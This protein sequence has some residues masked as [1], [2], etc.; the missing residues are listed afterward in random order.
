MPAREDQASSA[1]LPVSLA[2]FGER[3]QRFNPSNSIAVAFSGGPDSLALLILAAQWSRSL[4]GG[5]IIALT[6]DH[7]LRAGSAAEAERAAGLAASLGVPHRI[8]S[9]EG[10]KPVSGI[11]AAARDARYRL[12][13]QACRTFGASELL[14][15]HHLEDQAET[16]LLRLRR[17]SG[18]DGLAAMQDVRAL[19]MEEPAVRLLRPLLDLPRERL[20]AT[21]AQSGLEPILDPSNSNGQFD[22]VKIRQALG[23][24]AALGFDAAGLADT[25]ARMARARVALEAQTAALLEAHATLSSFGHV[26][27]DAEGLAAAPDETRLRALAAILKVVGGHAYGPR[28]DGLTAIDEALAD[29]TLGRG[30]TLSGVKFS[31]ARGRLLAVRELAAAQRASAFRLVAGEAATWDGRFDVRLEAGPASGVEVRVLG[32]EGLSV[33]AAAGLPLPLAPKTALVALPA[34]WVGRTLLGAPHL[35]TLD[36]ASE[37]RANLASLGLFARI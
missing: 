30:R 3:M 16:F 14:V 23:A 26:E 8:L 28:M 4:P 27:A 29:D 22:R 35:G 37:A 12:L 21:V 17:G 25:A 7:G 15:A 2:A 31:L 33:L 20:A 6:V 18:V 10:P 36:P 32:V 11:Q 19:D 1:R 34:L 24:L 13:G 5:Q 9:W